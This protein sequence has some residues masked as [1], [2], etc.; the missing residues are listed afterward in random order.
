MPVKVTVAL[1]PEQ[2]VVFAAIDAFGKG[3]TLIVTDPDCGWLQIGVPDDAAFTRF[4]TV[5]AV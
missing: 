1:E 3:R 4:I 5:L 2:I